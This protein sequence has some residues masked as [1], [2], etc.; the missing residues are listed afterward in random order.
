MNDIANSTPI[1]PIWHEHHA[2]T[3]TGPLY[4]RLRV[5]TRVNRRSTVNQL[6]ER[7]LRIDPNE[8]GGPRS[9]THDLSIIF[10]PFLDHG[11]GIVFDLIKS[12]V[13]NWPSSDMRR[14][15]RETGITSPVSV[16][17]VNQDNEQE[18][19]R[20]SYVFDVHKEIL[21]WV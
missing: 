10:C 9:C 15:M 7:F 2:F 13:Y 20:V 21:D 5:T 1:F 11:N 17:S 6:L 12:L 4:H 19:F 16:D 14:K 3:A 8:R 18:Y